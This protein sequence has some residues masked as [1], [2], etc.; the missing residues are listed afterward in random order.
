MTHGYAGR[1]FGSATGAF[2]T[3][4]PL[5][6]DTRRRKRG[7]NLIEQI[8]AEEISKAGK[9]IPEFRA[10]DTLRDRKST[11]LNS[12]HTDISRMPSSA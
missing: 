4:L 6:R 1:T 11:R 12:S 5:A 8:E 2:G 3:D 10:G 9:Q 7:M